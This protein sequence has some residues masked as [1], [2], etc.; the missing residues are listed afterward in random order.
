MASKQADSLLWSLPCHLHE[1]KSSILQLSGYGVHAQFEQALAHSWTS[2]QSET[3]VQSVR[4]D[5]NSP[6]SPSVL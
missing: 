6:E 5:R 1:C 4:K 2:E 3:P